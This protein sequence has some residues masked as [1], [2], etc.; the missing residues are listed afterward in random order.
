MNMDFVRRSCRLVGIASAIRVRWLVAVV[1]LLCFGQISADAQQVEDAAA[2]LLVVD[3]S[4]SMKSPTRSGKSRWVEM[5]QRAVEFVKTVPLGSRVWLSVF[6]SDVSKVK[7]YVVTIATEQQRNA[8]ISRIQHGYGNPTGGTALYDTLGMAFEEA[9]RL[10]QKTPGRYI[11]VMVFTD[12]K[13]GH[14]KKWKDRN[15]LE[16][17]FGKLIRDNR[18]LWLFITPLEGAPKPLAE[19]SRTI[20]GSAKVPVSVRVSPNTVTLANPKQNPKQLATIKLD[21]SQQSLKFVGDQPIEIEFVPAAGD[22]IRARIPQSP[23]RIKLGT[24]DVL[25]EVTNAAQLQ[26]D[27][28]YQGVLKLKY[29]D[30][31][32][33]VIQGATSVAVVFQKSEPPKVFDLRPK[34]GQVFAA[35]QDVVMFVNTLQSAKVIWDFGDGNS[36][37]GHRVSHAYNTA[38]KK[39][40]TVKVQGGAGTQPTA[41]EIDLEIID[42]GV[43]IDPLTAKINEGSPYTFTC[44]GRGGIQRFEWI[45]DGRTYQGKG[46]R[47]ESLTYTFDRAGDHV[48]SVRALHPKLNVDSQELSVGVTAKPAVT[49]VDPQADAII[50]LGQRISMNANVAGPVTAIAWTITKK[51]ES[52]PAYT[53][54]TPVTEVGLRKLA[55]LDYS[56]AET[57]SNLVDG[58][59][60]I[61]T[62]TCKL[63]NNITGTAPTYSLPLKLKAPDRSVRIVQPVVGQKL[64]FD[65]EVEFLAEVIGPNVDRV[66]W[67]LAKADGANPTRIET[68]VIDEGGRRLARLKRTFGEEASDLQVDVKAAGLLPPGYVTSPPSD[69]TKRQVK[70]RDFDFDI[71]VPKEIVGYSNQPIQFALKP[72]K[73]F[74]DLEWDFGDGQ[75]DTSKNANPAHEFKATGTYK[76]AALITGKGNRRYAANAHV[77]IK[78]DPPKALLDVTRDGSSVKEVKAGDIVDLVQLTNEPIG[79]VV[80]KSWFHNGEPIEAGQ[81]S[82]ALNDIGEHKITLR[83]EGPPDLSGNLLTDEQTLVIAVLPKPDHILF[84]VVLG[85]SSLFIVVTWRWLSGNAP[86]TWRVY[87]SNIGPPDEDADPAVRVKRYWKWWR[88]G[89]KYAEIPMDKLFIESEH[90]G[91]GTGKGESLTIDAFKL[92]GR[93]QGSITYS[94]EGNDSVSCPPPDEDG[95][96][97]DYKIKDNR[98]KEEDYKTLYIRLLKRNYE[99]LKVWG[100]KLLILLAVSGAVWFVWQSVYRVAGE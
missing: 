2:Y 57:N 52:Q 25:V 30:L 100:M 11:A 45:V 91:G 72:D 58:A 47:G 43:T 37:T 36:D 33:H 9:E 67:T 87:Y 90:W 24:I 39:K 61:V 22:P 3:H 51:G 98:C 50:T 63:A 48:V 53:V 59:E 21:V 31:N 7:P 18:N 64:Y 13:D 85:L 86:F 84:A 71:V 78:A 5:Q 42:V 16:A 83:V 74:V 89:R 69:T 46:D 54:E 99:A 20:Y 97:I 27:R 88:L 15:A 14:S 28:E 19:G 66:Q 34:S 35:G 82:L 80:K 17:R 10:S 55:R 96:R 95:K 79:D 8:L 41:H 65:S 75:R 6:S 94:G 77:T 62:A 38:G 26:T 4:A 44:T 40:V 12:G 56:F 92:S 93:W 49:I 70:H 73:G 32:R 60:V 76:I 81:I 23:Y 29:P 1:A 68:P